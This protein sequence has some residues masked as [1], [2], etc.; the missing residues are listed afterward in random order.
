VDVGLVD[1]TFWS[2]PNNFE[3]LLTFNGC[4]LGKFYPLIFILMEKKNEGS[5]DA[6]FK[7]LLSL[8]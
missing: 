5:Y 4:F 7:K 2:V 1:G 3:Q 6:A 8:V